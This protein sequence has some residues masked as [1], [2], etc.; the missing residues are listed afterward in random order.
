MNIFSYLKDNLKSVILVVQVVV[1]VLLI[2]VILIQSKGS[3]LSEIFGG[4]GSIYSTRRGLEKRLHIFT[5][6]LAF[7]FLV[8]AAISLKIK[9]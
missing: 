9:G 1:S 3:S 7:L 4:S 6:I 5:I 8:L 2:F